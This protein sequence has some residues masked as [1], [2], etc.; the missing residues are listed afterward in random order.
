MAW[1]LTVF[2]AKAGIQPSRPGHQLRR[3]E[4]AK[5]V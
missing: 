1:G 4:L 2:P 5:G 3:P